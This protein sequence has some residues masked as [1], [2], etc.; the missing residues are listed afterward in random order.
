MADLDLQATGVVENIPVLDLSHATWEEDLAGIDRIANVG[1]VVVVDNLAHALARISMQ[2]VGAVIPVPQ[3]S[4]VRVLTGAIMLGGDA[5]A[6]PGG[7]NEVL[8]VIGGLILTSPVTRIG[9]RAVVITGL[10]LA[11]QGSES[12]LGAGLTGM[13]G[14]VSYYRYVQGQEFRHL[15]GQVR[16]SGESVANPSG[17]PDDVLVLMGQ[18]IVSS[19]VTRVGYQQV[20][21]TGQLVL[22]RASE[23]VLAPALTGAGQVA[24]YGG[25]PRFY[26]GDETFGR[27]FFELLDEPLAL[28]VIG[29]VRIEDDVPA[30]LLRA[31]VS[32]ITVVGHLTVPRKLLPV[33]QLLT[34]ERYGDVA[35]SEDEPAG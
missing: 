5:L 20:C 13:T 9:Y 26:V 29:S 21:Y 7:D 12:V 24:W 1:A 3:G 14:S 16:L 25:R 11:P 28:A 35:V 33:V 6:E 4:R 8:V 17:S 27:E 30:E 10:L 32:E 2:N 23:A 22:P 31:K 34:T 18:V 15:T 19:P